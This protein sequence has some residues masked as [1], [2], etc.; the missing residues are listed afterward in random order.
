LTRA[1]ECVSPAA[2]PDSNPIGVLAEGNTAEDLVVRWQPMSREDWNG[3]G[4]GY[5]IK[6]RPA[7]SG[8]NEFGTVWDASDAADE[9]D[10]WRTQTVDD[11]HVDHV[12]IDDDDIEMYTPYEVQVLARNDEGDAMIDPTTKKGFSGQGGTSY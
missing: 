7:G 6:Y 8:N 2:R 1:Q 12:V 5:T 11:P 9:R 3:P 10:G 4:F